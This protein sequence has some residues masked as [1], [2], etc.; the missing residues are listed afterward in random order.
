[1]TDLLI[2]ALILLVIAFTFG[3]DFIYYVLYVI[4][5]I[6]LTSQFAIPRVIHRL[7][8]KRTY[9]QNAFLGE[10][11]EV[12]L[13]ISNRS[14][15]PI[16]WLRAIESIPPVLRPGIGVN[17]AMTFRYRESK[18]LTYKVK[19]MKRG[20]YRLGPLLISAGDLF[21]IREINGQ[22]APDYLTVFP[23]IVGLSQ[24]GLSSR[25]PYGTITTKHRIF[26]DPARPI[27]IR[28]YRSGD[29]M[30]HINWKVSAHSDELLVR[31]FEPVKSLETLILLNL[32]PNEYSR[33]TRYD[34]PEWAIVVAASIASHLAT[35]R[36]ASGLVT[37]GIDPLALLDED[38]T[39]SFDPE[40][41]RLEFAK[42]VL[43]LSS[44]DQKSDEESQSEL[45]RIPPR[46]GR[47]H[48][49]KILEKLARVEAQGSVPFPNWVPRA[50]TNLSWG[51]TVIAITP[52]GDDKTCAAL[53]QLVKS[54]YNPVL[55]VIE[56]YQDVREIRDKARGL[57][58]QAYKVSEDRDLARWRTPTK[59][60]WV[61]G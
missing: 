7:S 58:F 31:T 16:P 20:Y 28:D 55:I 39:E 24:L 21:G 60:A 61:S 30:R 12:R 18:S 14:W 13:T 42:K 6:Y 34:G 38:G 46:P 52:T 22:L 8:L 54:G 56:T 29:S 10:Q 59:Q 25:L 43:H 41:G 2:L 1:M 15:L 4:L 48:L 17:Q 40:T 44:N 57:G 51:V 50:C 37:N 27:G 5:G 45:V 35:L 23:R 26:E 9:N 19:A 36:Q 49:M 3:V 33:Q 32:N 47:A 53:H 11:V